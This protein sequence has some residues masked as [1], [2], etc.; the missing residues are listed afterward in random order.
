MLRSLCKTH[1]QLSDAE[2]SY[3]E[4]LEGFLPL[5][6]EMVDA[7]IF[8]DC[9]TRNPDAAIV[10]AEANAKH[11]M[12]K[13]TVVGQLAYRK[14]EPAALRTLDIGIPTFELKAITQEAITVKQNVVAIRYEG[15]VIGVL[16]MEMDVTR[17]YADKRSMQIL[18]DTTEQLA[19]ALMVQN[20]SRNNESHITN[21]VA[22]AILIAD[23][24]GHIIYSNPGAQKLYE[25][26]GYRDNLVGMHFDNVVLDSS[27][28]QEI[29][30]KEYLEIDEVRIGS[31]ALNIKYSVMKQN[32]QEMG[33]VVHVRDITEVKN[34]EKELILKSVAIREIH[35][36]VKNNLQTI[37]SLLRIQ[38]R[39]ITDQNAKKAF[40]E[41]IS[42]VLSIAVTHELLAQNGVDDVDIKDILT[43]IVKGAMLFSNSMHFQLNVE[44]KGDSVSINSEKATSIA[45][46]VN[47]LVQ[48]C[49]EYAFIGRS[50]G[51][52]LITIEK[53]EYASVVT[54]S[55]DG[56][57]FQSQKV[58]MGSLGLSIVEQLIKDKLKG[59][60][61]I[62]SGP[63]GTHIRFDFMHT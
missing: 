54:V 31:L 12:Y 33:L 19:Q 41:S 14:N 34:K 20:A 23:Q 49:V 55:D 9:M 5:I 25:S 56:I 6:A 52:I 40:D 51:N 16:I 18:K 21:Y 8:I 45:L 58:K 29:R 53:G 26:L 43:N 4:A 32:D 57:G 50:E 46:V 35:H 47:E 60:L 38:S 27:T 28:L 59:D 42:R 24:D 22:D 36:R 11:S 10:V 63:H 39:R 48:N 17:D 7:D 44:V 3:L 30:E 61:F 37:A 15:K 1:T 62:N 13:D 2:I